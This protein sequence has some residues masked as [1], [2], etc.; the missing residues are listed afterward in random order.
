LPKHWP[1]SNPVSVPAGTTSPRT[2]SRQ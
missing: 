1:S 2:A